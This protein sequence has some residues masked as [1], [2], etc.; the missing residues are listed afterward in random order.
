MQEDVA[1]SGGDGTVIVQH[2]GS[3]YVNGQDGNGWSA[4]KSLGKLMKPIFA[5]VKARGKQTVVDHKAE[6]I[7]A[8]KAVGKKAAKDTLASIGVDPAAVGLGVGGKRKKV[9]SQAQL[10]ALANGRAVRA[11]L[12]AEKSN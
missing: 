8:G 11:Q 5:D 4:M 10:D 7:N 3:I 6:V 9:L 2:G 1:Y 12:A